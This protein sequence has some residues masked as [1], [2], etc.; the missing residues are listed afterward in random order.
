MGFWFILNFEDFFFTSVQLGFVA[1]F[2]FPIKRKIY[3]KFVTFL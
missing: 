3:N 2:N 1:D